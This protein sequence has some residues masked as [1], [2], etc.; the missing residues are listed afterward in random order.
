MKTLIIDADD[1]LWENNIHF[2]DAVESFLDLIEL[3]DNDKE[4]ARETLDAVERKNI[5]IHGYGSSCF[6]L[7]LTDTLEQLCRRPASPRQRARILELAAGVRNM[8]IQYL[9][10]VVPTLTALRVRYRLIL[11]TKGDIDEQRNKVERSGA[12]DYFHRVE[13]TPEKDPDDYLRII[14][15]HEIDVG[16][17]WMVGNSP[18]SDINPALEVGLGAIFIPHPRTWT[19]EHQHVRPPAH[20]RFHVLER[21]EELTGLK[22]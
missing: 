6:A 14:R 4:S 3:G 9:P 18:R 20:D 8:P 11:F 15:T 5:P 19:L 10:G 13:V 16:K 2:E 22:L 7:S 12:A 17:S 1:T 21:F